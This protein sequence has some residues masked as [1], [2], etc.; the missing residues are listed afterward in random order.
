MR[1]K[2]LVKARVPAKRNDFREHHVDS[3]Y[4]FAR[5]A[6]RREFAMHFKDECMI[7]SC[8]D[9]NKLKVG[10]LAVSRYHQVTKFFPTDD[11]PNYADHDFPIPG[12]KLITSGYMI[13][14]DFREKD[15]DH[16]SDHC[17]KFDAS[18]YDFCDSDK[19]YE[20]MSSTPS[21]AN[22]TSS[23]SASTTQ[24]ASESTS[25]P[26]SLPQSPEPTSSLQSSSESASTVQSG[27]S[28]TVSVSTGAATASTSI[29][30]SQVQQ[31]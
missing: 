23:E 10:T 17:E 31:L 25:V 24:S 4:L 2:S 21:A 20:A 7:L 5:A 29:S 19:E 26:Q 28:V 13:L 1:Y 15:S 11:Q 18:E 9:M 12:Y 8:D 27:S 16:V 22:L 30:C 3:H 6:Y 14:T